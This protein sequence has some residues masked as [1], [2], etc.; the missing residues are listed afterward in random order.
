MPTRTLRDNA[1]TTPQI[2]R[3]IF[4]FHDIKNSQPLLEYLAKEIG[5]GKLTAH[6][7]LC[8]R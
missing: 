3:G 1:L 8:I 5:E 2:L 7:P 4:A 6:A